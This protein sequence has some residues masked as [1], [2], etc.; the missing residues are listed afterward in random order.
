MA[1][2][3][4][5]HNVRD[6]TAPV[7]EP[8]P[9]GDYHSVIV[10]VTQKMTKTD[11]L[12]ALA[13]EFQITET[14]KDSIVNGEAADKYAGR[15]IYQDYVLAPGSNDFNNQRGAFRIQQLMAAT[16]CPHKVLDGGMITFNTDH[17]LAKTVRISVTR[18]AG[19]VDPTDPKKPIPI[20]NNVDRVDSTADPEAEG[21][22]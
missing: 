18:S 7:R 6:A 3:T 13:I 8:V 10:K 12:P 15:S 11:N 1:E 20:F 2:I 16:S 19:K 14:Q 22:V 17:L 5:T 9:S 4:V 21:M